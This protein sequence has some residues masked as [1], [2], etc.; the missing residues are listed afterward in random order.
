MEWSGIPGVEKNRVEFHTHTPL[1]FHKWNFYKWSSTKFVAFLSV[2][3]VA[4]IQAF[5]PRFWSFFR[6][7]GIKS[8]AIAKLRLSLFQ[9]YAVLKAIVSRPYT[10]LR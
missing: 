9:P 3:T 10:S 2:Y 6:V 7:E 8:M 1:Q 4:S 5:I